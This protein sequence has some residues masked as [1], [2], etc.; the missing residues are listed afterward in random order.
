MTEHLEESRAGMARKFIKF[1]KGTGRWFRKGGRNI[2]VPNSKIRK[3]SGK[4]AN[5]RV[6]GDQTALAYV[7]EKKVNLGR[8]RQSYEKSSSRYT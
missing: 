7:K 2:W 1:I 8:N 4:V 5:P 6:M 3:T